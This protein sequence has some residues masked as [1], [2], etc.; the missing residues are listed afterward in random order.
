MKVLGISSNYH[1]ASAA[2]VVDGEVI[3]SA[4][5]ERFTRQK[6]DPTF[7][8]HSIAHCLKAAGLTAQQLD[9]VV[10]HEDP[11]TKLTRTLSSS[12]ARWPV[13]LPTFLKTARE[14]MTGGLWIENTISKHLSVSPSQVLFAPHHLSHAAQAFLGSGFEQSAVMTIDAVGEWISSAIF[15]ARFENGRAVL[16]PVQVSP[17]PNSL[18]LAYSAFTSYL[19]F[20]VNDGEC[21]TMALAAFGEPRFA[22]EVRRIIHVDQSGSHQIDLSYFDFR[23]DVDLPVTPK[24]IA[25]FGSPR[26]Y[27]RPLPFNSITATGPISAEDQRFADIAASLQLVTEEAVVAYARAAAR[28]TGSRNLCYGGGVALNCVANSRLAE[29]GVFE[30]IFIPPDPGDGGG[31]M[32]AALY[33]HATK[34]G[35]APGKGL[36]PYYGAEPGSAEAAAYG[37][38]LDPARWHHFSRLPLKPLRRSSLKWHEFNSDS[39]LIDAVC[40]RLHAGKAVGWVQGRFE[41]GPRA[42]GNRSILLRPDN[43]ALATDLSVQVKLRASFRPYAISLTD[44]EAA[45]SLEAAPT[46][47]APRWMQS[48]VR[49]KPE[50]A[51]ELRGGMHVDGTTRAQVVSRGDN[52]LFYNLLDAYGRLS[53]RAALINTSFNES[54]FPIVANATDALVTFA[55]TGLSALAFGRHLVEKEGP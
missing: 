37:Q 44:S 11:V 7:P 23:G 55:R 14:F 40:T 3:A 27:R 49:V 42:L 18:G 41:S 5:E 9:F 35:A 38:L 47:L 39:E 29:S 1:D 50:A 43:P 13:S 16:E 2:L 8:S 32:G 52:P 31:A 26:P 19:G 45:R 17:F 54:G 28:L 34:A 48:A 6:H 46:A 51:P 12:L 25:A 21:S 20:K 36:H 33:A 22:E 15:L 30:K 10:Y 4:A 53:G 24:F